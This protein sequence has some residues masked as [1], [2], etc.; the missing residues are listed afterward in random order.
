MIKATLTIQE[1]PRG[2]IVSVE[3]PPSADTTEKELSMGWALSLVIR[4]T[5]RLY[6]G[7]G[8]F[9]WAEGDVGKRLMEKL[10]KPAKEG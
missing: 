2:V 1:G 4:E 6:S 8:P 3:T 10:G 9:L 5:C 7:D